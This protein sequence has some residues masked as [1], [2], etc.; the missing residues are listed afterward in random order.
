MHTFYLAGVKLKF[1]VN[2]RTL[3]TRHA[4]ASPATSNEIPTHAVFVVVVVVFFVTETQ[5]EY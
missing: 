4:S 5:L 1:T 2:V 3:W